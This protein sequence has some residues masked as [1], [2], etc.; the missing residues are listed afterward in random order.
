MSATI[1][2]TLARAYL[3]I[4]G[5]LIRPSARTRLLPLIIFTT[6]GILPFIITNPYYRDWM[7]MTYLWAGLGCAW[8]I[9][10]GYAGQLSIG[11]TAFF[12]LGA[13]VSSILLTN[14]DLSPWIGML[15]GG[16]IALLAAI[17]IGTATLRLRGPFFVLSTIAFAEVLR[18]MAIAWRSLTQGSLGIIIPFRPGLEYMSWCSKLPYAVIAFVYMLLQYSVCAI[19]Q[20]SRFGYFLVALRE[21][22]EAAQALGVNTAR[23]KVMALVIS[24]FLTA[25][26]GTIYAQYT[27]FIEPH[28]VL[29]IMTSVQMVLISIVGG[30]GTALGPILGALFV[31]PLGS[32]LRGQLVMVSGLHGLVYGVVL[33]IISLLLPQGLFG[34]LSRRAR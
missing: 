9:I 22:E 16:L 4:K 17:V 19:I 18:L 12:G 33:V 20:R 21:N 26:G 2:N 8:N 27:L 23:C 29:D 3:R 34:Y 7:F 31:V 14:Y 6:L 10:G 1:A 25:L 5:I 15:A 13:Y 30:L 24:A 28:T 32:F 11:H